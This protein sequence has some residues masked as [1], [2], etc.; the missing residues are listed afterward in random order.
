M[1]MVGTVCDTDFHAHFVQGK[2]LTAHDKLR[3]KLKRSAQS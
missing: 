3:E 1:Q 2:L